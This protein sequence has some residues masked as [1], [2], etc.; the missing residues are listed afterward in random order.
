VEWCN[1]TF[2]QHELFPAWC[3]LLFFGFHLPQPK[4]TVSKVLLFFNKFYKAHWT[5]SI[6]PANLSIMREHSSTLVVFP[7]LEILVFVV[8]LYRLSKVQI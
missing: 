6:S 4:K 7:I 8:I 2:V 3:L 1:E 5:V